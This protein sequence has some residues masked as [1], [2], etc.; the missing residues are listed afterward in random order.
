MSRYISLL[1]FIGLAFWGCEEEQDTIPPTVSIQSP[2]TS[3]TI[4]EIVTIVVETNDNEGI[5]R[6]EFYIDDSLFFTDTESPYQYDWN[7]TQY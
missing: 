6:V 3:Q 2:I 5:N 7:T 1:L 4:N